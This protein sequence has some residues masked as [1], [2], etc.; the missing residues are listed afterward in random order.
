MLR[1]QRIVLHL[2][3]GTQLEALA[4]ARLLARR[5]AGLDHRACLREDFGTHL[6]LHVSQA[7]DESLSAVLSRAVTARFTQ[8]D[9]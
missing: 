4:S 6:T 9:R 3:A 2:P 7:A 1:V 5:M 8:G